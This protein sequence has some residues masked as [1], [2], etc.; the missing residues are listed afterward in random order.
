MF[1]NVTFRVGCQLR[2]C[3]R[4][5]FSYVSISRSFELSGLLNFPVFRRPKLD[6]KKT[7]LPN[8]PYI[9][10][11]SERKPLPKRTVDTKKDRKFSFGPVFLS[12]TNS[13]T[14]CLTFNT[15]CNNVGH[16]RRRPSFSFFL[17]KR[18]TYLLLR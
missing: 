15:L 18:K 14:H 4:N 12:G 8:F 9:H 6:Q 17:T 1:Q 5:L 2:Q 11:F 13:G 7:A 3:V 10:V 16:R